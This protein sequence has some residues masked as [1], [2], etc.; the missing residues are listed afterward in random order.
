M[1]FFF[2]SSLASSFSSN[3]ISPVDTNKDFSYLVLVSL[4]DAGKWVEGAAETEWTC[5]IQEEKP[6][7]TT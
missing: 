7:T 4:F 1:V 2:C 3:Y 6:E 5:R